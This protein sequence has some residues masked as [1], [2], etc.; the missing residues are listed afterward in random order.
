MATPPPGDGSILPDGWTWGDIGHG[1]LD[2]V[3]VVPLFGEGADLVNAAWYA[4]EGN[5][6]DAGL[7]V[8]SMV[9]VVGDIIG[10]GGKIAKKAGGKL[11]G[12]ALDALRKMDF[13]KTLEPLRKHPKI[14]PHVDKMI[15]ALEKWRK[16]LIGEAPPC[17]PGGTQVCPLGKKPTVSPAPK[18]PAGDKGR[19]IAGGAD[20]RTPKDRSVFYSGPGNRGKALHAAK[21]GGVPIDATPGGK[22]LNDEKLYG[23]FAPVAQEEADAIWSEAS[24]KFAKAASGDVTAFVHGAS[25]DRVFAQ[26]ELPILLKNKDVNAI[27]GISRQALEEMERVKPGSAFQAIVAASAM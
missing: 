26:T 1:V 8:I 18:T 15:E 24:E 20:F 27:N 10:K 25:P 19:A 6:L 2:V 11:A 13:K 14:G 9:P 5:Y 4:A 22:A 12:P 16:D 21:N 17:T 7:S 3:G 23:E